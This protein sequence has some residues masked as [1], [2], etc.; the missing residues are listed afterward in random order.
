MINLDTERMAGRGDA[1]WTGFKA[2]KLFGLNDLCEKYI[3]KDTHMLELGCNACVSTRLFCHYAGHVTGVDLHK[4]PG[5]DRTLSEHNNFTFIQAA[6]ATFFQKN[7]DTF[8]LIYIDGTHTYEP[9]IQDIR[10][11]LPVIKRPGIVCGHDYYTSSTSGVPR[12][13]KEMFPEVEPEVFSDSSWL[14]ELKVD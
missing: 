14:V 3:T 8:D 12:A 4:T 5:V 1:E 7:K 9:A 6:F 11:S 2:N 13:V 10:N